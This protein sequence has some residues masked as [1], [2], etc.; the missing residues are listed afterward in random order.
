MT[1]SHLETVTIIIPV[2]NVKEYLDR[3]IVSVI[4]QS[5]KQLQILIIDDGSTDGSAEICDSWADRDSRIEVHHTVN[6]GLSAARNYGI[7]Y[8]KGTRILFIDSDD[9]IGRY[10]VEEL[11]NSLKYSNNPSQAIAVTGFTPVLPS[12]VLS[13]DGISKVRPVIL[14]ASEAIAESV[15]LGSRFGAHAWGKLYP[16][17]LL[18][19]LSYPVGRYYE[20]Q[21]VTYKAFIAASEILYI[22]ADDY[23]YV[24]QRKGAISSGK[25]IRE[26]DYLDAI[27]ETYHE[28]TSEYPE[29]KNATFK[30]YLSSLIAG[31]EIS[32]LFNKPDVAS[33]LYEEAISYRNEALRKGALK[34]KDRIKYILLGMGYNLFS[35]FTKERVWLSELTFS[36]VLNKFKRMIFRKSKR[37]LL[38]SYLKLRDSY[39]GH[40]CFLMMTPRY[41]NYG[42]QLIAFSENLL[43]N[44]AGIF[45]VIEIPYED[46]RAIGPKFSKILKDGDSVLF[47]GGGY[48]GDLWQ[49]LEKTTESILSC[50][51]TYNKV[52]FF[53]QSIFFQEDIDY[54][55]SNL[56][57]LVRNCCSTCILLSTR[58]RVTTKR[59]QPYL[60][61]DIIKMLP[62]V[63]LF[64]RW[65]DLINERP[66]RRSNL[67]LVCIRHD[68]ESLQDKT[69][70]VRLTEA[71]IAAGMQISSID[72]HD[73]EGEI[74]PDYRADEIG[75]LAKKFGEASVVITN[76]LHG[77]VLAMIMGTPCIVLDNVSGKV[78]GV[79]QW[80][81]CDYPVYFA[82]NY[83][84]SAELI[85]TAASAQF[86]GD[87]SALVDRERREMISILKELA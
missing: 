6:S 49:D 4:N 21:F 34:T 42:D 69:F 31:L 47:T 22:P 5:Y 45:N 59:L 67:S 81:K 84:V 80:V 83:D 35:H 24:Q 28:L 43:L 48:L 86:K 15:T 77:M 12:Q 38:H 82:N 58:E 71:L 29:A 73:P 50:V 7:K 32:I 39:N 56:I 23:Y 54:S 72:T 53:P 62:D 63:G 13:N 2:Y 52:L 76:R 14:N 70:G 9:Y 1:K 44:E 55:N 78:F 18:D 51:R 16:K 75:A 37:N 20:D 60:K 36:R 65:N 3:C 10:H 19:V 66:G 27:R 74:T 41:K 46:C 85:K 33:S 26:L 68:K 57:K 40:V 25:K 30:R 64:V 8:V 61:Q 87:V 79:A 11:V 17:K